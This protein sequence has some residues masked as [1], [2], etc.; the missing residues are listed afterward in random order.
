[1]R[2]LLSLFL[3]TLLSLSISC[4]DKCGCAP[5]ASIYDDLFGSWKWVKTTTPTKT[6]LAE[7]AG[8]SK[9][10]DFV[11]DRKV[12]AV[13]ITFYK[14]DSLQQNI[15]VS[16]NLEDSWENK[17]VLLKYTNDMQLK[18]FRSNELHNHHYNI[19]VSAIMPA[20]NASA[21]TVRHHYRFV[22]YLEDI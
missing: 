3:L 8:Y 21:D 16:K 18:Y 4:Q 9:T 10:M 5:P 12:Q 15:L 20:Y 19:E 11:F 22:K 14:N 7:N 13:R 2:K 17:S 6:I 1:M